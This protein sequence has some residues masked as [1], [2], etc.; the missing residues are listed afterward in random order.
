MNI[1]AKIRLLIVDDQTLVREGLCALL[2]EV[3]DIEVVGE[4]ADGAQ[5]VAMAARLQPDV[6]LM[7]LVMPGMNGIEA[8]RIITSRASCDAAS[9]QAQPHVV[10]LTS[11][12]GDDQVYPALKAGA[13]GYVLKDSRSAELVQAIQQVARNESWLHPVIARKVLRELQP[14]ASQRSTAFQLTAREI[15]V[16]RLVAR[17]ANDTDIAQQL[18]I[19]EVTVRSHVSNIL[20]KLHLANRVQATLYA[21]NQGLVSLDNISPTEPADSHSS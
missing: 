17:G 13:L 2:A 5:A 14:S 20:D 8:T 4:A 6:V 16:L 10:V 21:L 1:V 19:S 15:E 12:A 3:P 9:G 18:V 11:F 7:D